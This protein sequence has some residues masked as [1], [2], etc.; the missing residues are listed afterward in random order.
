MVTLLY[1]GNTPSTDRRRRLEPPTCYDWQR[2][3]SSS[4][5]RSTPFDR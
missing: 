1:A 3:L 4:A 5:P 2:S